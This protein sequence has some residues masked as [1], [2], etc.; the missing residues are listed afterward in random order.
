MVQPAI[1][2]EALG[3]ESQRYNCST[4]RRGNAVQR[5]KVRNR[6]TGLPSGRLVTSPTELNI[7]FKL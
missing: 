1:T 6:T 3:T 7:T 5:L 4:I 2:N